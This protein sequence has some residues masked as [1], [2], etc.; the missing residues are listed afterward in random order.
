ML[1]KPGLLFFNLCMFFFLAACARALECGSRARRNRGVRIARAT[2]LS[3]QSWPAIAVRGDGR[4]HISRRAC[5][6][7]LRSLYFS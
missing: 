1:D 3:M 4:I 7:E 2:R 5:F 6:G